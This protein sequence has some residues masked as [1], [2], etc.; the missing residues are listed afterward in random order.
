MF[1]FSESQILNIFDNKE[2]S[3]M[4]DVGAG[5][6]CVTEKFKK[7]IKKEI[8]CNEY[9][10]KMKN[11]LSNKGFLIIEDIS[12]KEV[13]DMEFDIV[14]C[15]NVLDRCDKPL[16]IMKNLFQLKKKFVI[17]RFHYY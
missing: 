12:T 16:S 7:I 10:E 14:A 8:Y 13:R 17:L 2:Y 3:T 4:L 5:D 6:G 15:L 11:V 9:S 1:L